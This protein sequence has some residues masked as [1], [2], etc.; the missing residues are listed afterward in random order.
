MT[1]NHGEAKRA[2]QTTFYLLFEE[3]AAAEHV[4]LVA[5]EEAEQ[6]EEIIRLVQDTTEDVPRF[7]SST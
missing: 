1:R 7:M 3:L 2:D 4:E 6:I 5:L